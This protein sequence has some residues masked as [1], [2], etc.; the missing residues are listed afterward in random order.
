VCGPRLA[1]SAYRASKDRSIVFHMFIVFHMYIV[2][3]IYSITDLM[4]NFAGGGG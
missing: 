1:G 2:F 3:N 4:F